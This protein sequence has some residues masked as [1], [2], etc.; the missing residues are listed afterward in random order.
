MRCVLVKIPWQV[1]GLP[2]HNDVIAKSSFNL[3][4]PGAGCCARLKCEGNLFEL[5][6]QAALG[7]PTQSAA[8]VEGRSM[9]ATARH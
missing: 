9:L 4:E 6:I 8:C 3:G 5:G 2:Y 7:L 1:K